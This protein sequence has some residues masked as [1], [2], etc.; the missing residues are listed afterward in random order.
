MEGP[1]DDKRVR[2]ILVVIVH[3]VGAAIPLIV[4]LHLL[5][6]VGHRVHH[7]CQVAQVLAG[8]ALLIL[9]GS[10]DFQALSELIRGETLNIV[11]KALRCQCTELLHMFLEGGRRIVA[12]LGHERE[13]VDL[14]DGHQQLDY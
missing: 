3:S 2:D 10:D 9:P 7:W 12:L 1:L 8:R 14:L 4:F 6:V 11:P 13:L 5:D